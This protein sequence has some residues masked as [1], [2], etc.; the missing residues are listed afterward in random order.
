MKKSFVEIKWNVIALSWFAF[1]SLSC[2]QNNQ[3]KKSDTRNVVETISCGFLNVIIIIEYN[4]NKQ[5][6]QIS[7][8]YCTLKILALGN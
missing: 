6:F 2:E 3:W 5:S 7:S 1:I 4:L 8:F